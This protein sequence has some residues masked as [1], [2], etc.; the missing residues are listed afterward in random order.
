MSFRAQCRQTDMTVA[1]LQDER[2]FAAVVERRSRQPM[3]PLSVFASPVFRAV[4]LVTLLVYAALGGV[5]FMLVLALH[6]AG[7]EASLYVG[8]WSNW[9]ADPARPIA[10]GEQP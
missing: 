8:S 4:N 3:M 1:E 9:I 6:T 10:R 5:F 2:A 7:I